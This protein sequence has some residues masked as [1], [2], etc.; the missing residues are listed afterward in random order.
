MIKYKGVKIPNTA[1]D[2]QIYSSMS[3]AESAAQELTNALKKA[4]GAFDQYMIS[5]EDTNKTYHS[6]YTKFSSELRGAFDTYDEYG[7]WDSEPRWVAESALK[8][9]IRRRWTITEEF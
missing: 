1:E 2:W 5:D 8:R 7:T 6:G 9:Y 3:G 4:F